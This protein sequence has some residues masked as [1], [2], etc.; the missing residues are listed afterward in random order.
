MR[1]PAL[2]ARPRRVGL[3][4]R[5]RKVAAADGGKTDGVK[6]IPFTRC[7]RLFNR[8]NNQLYRV[9]G[10]L[11]PTLPRVSETF[12]PPKPNLTLVLML[13]LLT[14][15]TVLSPNFQWLKYKFGA[16]ELCKKLGAL[17]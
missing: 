3:V 13:T 17:L 7:S 9:N 11:P 5:R 16:Q 12:A 10:V 8:F 15:L 4:R 6:K 1:A 2:R 14:L